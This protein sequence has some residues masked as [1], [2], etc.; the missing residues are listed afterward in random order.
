MIA[1][2]IQC[3]LNLDCDH[4][5]H[6][7]F[8]RFIRAFSDF[9]DS[10]T[11][12]SMSQDCQLPPRG[13][14]SFLLQYHLRYYSP[15]ESTEPPAAP[16]GSNLSEFFIRKRQLAW[17]WPTT[18]ETGEKDPALGYF[19]ERA[20]SISLIMYAPRG[21]FKLV[22]LCDQ[23]A[24]ITEPS[25]YRGGLLETPEELKSAPGLGHFHDAMRRLLETWHQGWNET[26]T[27]IDQIVGFEV[28]C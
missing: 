18:Q 5:I 1:F 21:A 14:R 10:T 7:G 15:L 26:L 11:Q 4:G 3:F 13:D 9:F 20:L 17:I 23:G 16:A 8:Y 28:S 27:V 24:G 25:I 22:V 2:L 6:G 19:K 12:R